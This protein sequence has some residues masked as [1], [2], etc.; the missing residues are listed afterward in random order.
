[1]SFQNST[2]CAADFV[3][4]TQKRS[5][6]LTHRCLQR[7]LD[8]LTWVSPG[9]F[10][11]ARFCLSGQPVTLRG[12]WCGGQVSTGNKDK[13]IKSLLSCHLDETEIQ[14]KRKAFSL[15][16]KVIYSIRPS[17]HPQ[18]VILLFLELNEMMHILS[19]AFP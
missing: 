16:F 14:T 8:L 7:S 13:V 2:S 6:S 3:Q 5:Q 19:Q 17:H 9:D 12:G 10:L 4:G 15:V 1:M 18:H 11:A